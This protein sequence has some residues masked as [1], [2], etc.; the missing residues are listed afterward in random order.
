MGFW[1][2][3][4]NVFGKS[5][6]VSKKA[7]SKAGNAIQD[8]SDKSVVKLEIKQYENKKKNFYADLGKY[9]GNLFL[10]EEKKT[11]KNTDE[12]VVQ[13]LNEI[14]NCDK[15]IE[16]R[17]DVLNSYLQIESNVKAPKEISKKD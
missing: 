7:V 9:V 14:Q 15:E 12:A 5:A 16:K 3:V 4:R 17:Q 1:E 10:V 13:I 11:I 8:F 2:N 6:E